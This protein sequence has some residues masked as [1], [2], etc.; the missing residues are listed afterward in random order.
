[1][2]FKLF[3]LILIFSMPS[4]F[5]QGVSHN[6]IRGH[7]V[8]INGGHTYI[9][10]RA[11]NR[12]MQI[13]QFDGNFLGEPLQGFSHGQPFRGHDTRLFNNQNT[14]LFFNHRSQ[15]PIEQNN[16]IFADHNARFN[17]AR[18]VNPRKNMMYLEI[19]S[20]SKNNS[21]NKESVSRLMLKYPEFNAEILSLYKNLQTLAN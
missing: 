16:R 3:L 13:H 18:N 10:G 11:I 12:E 20:L 1:M 9:S 14:R 8:H 4:I 19:K 21:L 6:L 15:V 5:A 17:A 2:V 7:N